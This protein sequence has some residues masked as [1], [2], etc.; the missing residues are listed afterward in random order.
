MDIEK[1]KSYG[2]SENIYSNLNC[3]SFYPNI[4][5]FYKSNQ[6]WEY[7]AKDFFV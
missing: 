5:V 7:Q 6:I 2:V 1:Y 4:I 3:I